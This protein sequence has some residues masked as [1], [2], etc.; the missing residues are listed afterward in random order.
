INWRKAG[1]VWP[2]RAVFD[3]FD[4]FVKRLG[5]V[6]L[7]PCNPVVRFEGRRQRTKNHARM[8]QVPDLLACQ[9][10][11]QILANEAQEIGFEFHVLQNSGDEAG[12]LADASQPRA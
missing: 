12:L 5:T 3:N 4:V 10:D 8:S 9:R 6:L 2:G 7:M 11:S 1:L